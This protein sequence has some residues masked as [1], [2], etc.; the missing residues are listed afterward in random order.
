M[1]SSDDDMLNSQEFNDYLS[2]I[3]YIMQRNKSWRDRV[4]EVIDRYV[5]QNCEG[6]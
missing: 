6:I 3:Y 5:H 2:E 1:V 4:H